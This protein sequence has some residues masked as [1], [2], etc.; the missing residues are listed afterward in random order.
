MF[1]K[2][3]DPSIRYT[4]RFGQL[5][6][7][8]TATAC[9]ATIDI[10]YSGRDCV[11]CFN[12]EFSYDPRGHIYVSV[13][14]G[15]RVEVTI[16][17]YVRVSAADE[18]V[19]FVKVIYKSS[20]EQQ[21]RWYLPLIG[22]LSFLGY[23]ADASASL[24]AD[25]RKTIEFVGDSITEGVL[26]DEFRK[27]YAVGQH[28]R[29]WQD[30]S[31]ATYAWLT[32]EALNLRPFCM[33]YGAVGNTHSGCGNV[34][35]TADAYPYNFENSPVTYPSCDYILINHGANDRGRS[36]YLDEYR[37]VLKLIRERNPESTIIVLS[38]F[39]GAFDDV[40]PGFVEEFNRDN[41]DDVKYISSQGWV[42]AEPLHPLRDGHKIIAEHLVEKMKD[43]VK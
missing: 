41:G 29:P 7:T 18:G 19:H 23:E 35:K 34:P 10:A 25:E 5:G 24:P 12:T 11:L 42:P 17:P 22:K 32:A 37:G 27:I 28:N 2:F 8:M 1:I 36:N 3:D 9:G 4:G 31:T 43:I 20:V 15:A 38:P 40:L 13:D 14:G 21:H 30:D 16:E 6:N 26:I 33:G 39:C